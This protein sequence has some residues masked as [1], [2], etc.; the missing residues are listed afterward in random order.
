MKICITIATFIIF[1]SINLA[2]RIRNPGKIRS[3]L[4]LEHKAVDK[5]NVKAPENH[6]TNKGIR[7][8]YLKGLQS[9]LMYQEINL[10]I[11]IL[12]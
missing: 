7:N 4:F 11:T 5:P 2:L 6:K 12:M 3:N 8:I 10:K 9:Q 1:C